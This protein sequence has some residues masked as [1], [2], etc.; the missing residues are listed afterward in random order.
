MKPRVA[1]GVS[2]TPPGLR[3]P[4]FRQM[5]PNRP[6]HF[7]SM[8]TRVLPIW[9]FVWH[10]SED[11]RSFNQVATSFFAS[12]YR[13]MIELWPVSIRLATGLA[14]VSSGFCNSLKNNLF[15]VGGEGRNRTGNGV[16][17]PNHPS[18]HNLRNLRPIA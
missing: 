15:G 17:S 13:A 2:V 1:L 7:S 10:C 14:G 9:H 16:G 3:I 18:N 8:F 6:A 4:F 11:F 5:C 12:I